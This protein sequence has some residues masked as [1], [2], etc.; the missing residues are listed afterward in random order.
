MDMAVTGSRRLRITET[1][2]LDVETERWCCNRC[3]RDLG[4]ATVNYKHAC[5]LAD[6]DPREVHQSFAGDP[7]FSFCPDH[8]WCAI[9]EVYC[10]GCGVLMEAEY[11]PPGH[12]LTHDVQIDLASLRAALA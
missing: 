4:E 9:V 8:E 6:R 2:D 5:L 12:P 3:D 10:P 1:L 7:E 11:L